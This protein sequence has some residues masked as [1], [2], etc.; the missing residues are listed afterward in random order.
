MAAAKRS[1]A[2]TSIRIADSANLSNRQCLLHSKLLDILAQKEHLSKLAALGTAG[3]LLSVGIN[4]K[5]MCVAI[6]KCSANF[7]GLY[8]FSVTYPVRNC[9]AFRRLYRL[10]FRET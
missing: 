6:W 4:C 10:S 9:V 1:V 2:W 8:F 5:L 3:S 7:S